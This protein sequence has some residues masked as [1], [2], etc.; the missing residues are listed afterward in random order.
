MVIQSINVAACLVIL[1]FSMAAIAKMTHHT[2]WAIRWAYVMACTGA[3]AGLVHPPNNVTQAL[4][5]CG[6]ACLLLANRRSK[7]CAACIKGQLVVFHDRRS[8]G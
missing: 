3:F 1:W 5:L 6:V 2:Y 4:V 8:H 7:G